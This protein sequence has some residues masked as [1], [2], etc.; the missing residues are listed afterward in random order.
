MN[1]EACTNH[2]IANP[3]A[4]ARAVTSLVDE[5]MIYFAMRACDE[6]DNCSPFSYAQARTRDR[7]PSAVSLSLVGQQPNRQ[8]LQVQFTAPGDDADV[9]HTAEYFFYVSSQTITANTIGDGNDTRISSA[10][11]L[12]AGECCFSP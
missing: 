2:V 5:T 6:A 4:S 10:A 9:R 11:P 7:A 1:S 12:A 3:Q 8:Q